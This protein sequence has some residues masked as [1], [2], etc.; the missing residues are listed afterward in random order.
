MHVN[1]HV[2][3][4]LRTKGFKIQKAWIKQKI[5][6]FPEVSLDDNRIAIVQFDIPD[7]ND[8]QKS[9][10]TKELLWVASLF[11]NVPHMG[12]LFHYVH[13]G[14][15]GGTRHV[16]GAYQSIG[17]THFI[18]INPYTLLNR[19]H[20]RETLIHEL[21]HAYHDFMAFHHN[22]KL[23]LPIQDFLDSPKSHYLKS[24]N[25]HLRRMIEVPKEQFPTLVHL[26]FSNPEIIWMLDGEA[27]KH[28]PGLHYKYGTPDT[29]PNIEK[30]LQLVGLF[31]NRFINPE[32]LMKV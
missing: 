7:L 1:K 32:E 20:L 13:F 29:M 3:R 11:R 4:A 22:V 21:M 14:L 10:F 2:L 30:M 24:S 5:K 18:L 19:K 6:K 16:M 27:R 8:K 9:N 15:Y 26:T 25:L 28:F 23:R 12:D 31:R 17:S